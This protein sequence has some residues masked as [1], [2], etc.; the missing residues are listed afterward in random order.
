M[1]IV[2]GFVVRQILGETVAIPSGESAHR[3][4][5]LIAL[6]GSART[7]FELLQTEQTEESLVQGLLEAFEVDRQTAC[8]DVA[9]FVGALRQNGLLIEND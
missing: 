8:A 1:R 4:S 9:E 6:N 2:S 5:G 3:L 7:L